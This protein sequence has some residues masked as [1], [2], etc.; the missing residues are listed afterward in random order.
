MAGP[1]NPLV[2]NQTLN[3][4]VANATPS[5]VES[6]DVAT[7]IIHDVGAAGYTVISTS[8][9]TTVATG[10]SVLYGSTVVILA[11]ATGAIQL[12]D[13]TSALTGTFTATAVNQTLYPGGT[14]G[15]IGVRCKTSI[16][17]VTTGTNANTWN[18]LWD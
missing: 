16:V 9:T 11:T 8:G 4:Q 2:P 13:G 17:V 12:F 7:G 14:A 3:K 5:F 15:P 1:V 6:G 10:P 18:I